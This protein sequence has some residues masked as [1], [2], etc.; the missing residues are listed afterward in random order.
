MLLWNWY[1]VLSVTI[2]E[3]RCINKSWQFFLILFYRKLKPMIKAISE[4]FLKAS[5]EAHPFLWK[6]YFIHDLRSCLQRLLS[7]RHLPFSVA[8]PRPWPLSLACWFFS[9]QEVKSGC[10]RHSWVE[11]A[12]Y[13]YRAFSYYIKNPQQYMYC[14]VRENSTFWLYAI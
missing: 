6:W 5:L 4:L 7:P 2:K 13:S 11:I 8:L 10:Q 3:N 14:P 1:D 9:K 12:K